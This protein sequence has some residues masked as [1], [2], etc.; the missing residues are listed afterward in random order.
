MAP[1]RRG[2]PAVRSLTLEAP[3]DT[4]IAPDRDADRDTDLS[5]R[6]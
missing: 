6:R 2:V 5:E 4:K 3:W 1:T